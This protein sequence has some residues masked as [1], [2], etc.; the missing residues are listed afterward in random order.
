MTRTKGKL[1]DEGCRSIIFLLIYKGDNIAMGYYVF[2]DNSNV[3]I[4]GKYA[5]AV[6]KGMATDILDAHNKKMC[7]NSW[8]LDFGKLLSTVVDGKLTEV[9][10]A[11]VIGSKPTQKDSLWKAMETAGFT[12]KTHQRNQANKEKKV[13]TGIVQYINDT[14]YEKSSEGDIFVLVMGDKDYVPVVET[15][16]RKNRQVVI[17]FWDNVAGELIAA[18]SNYMNLND[19]FEEITH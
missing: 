5:S 11:V 4:E 16:E 7:D 15:I 1:N 10:E 9:K 19:K 8:K 13:D 18:A 6:K 2:M 14:L 17:A 3:W 12:V